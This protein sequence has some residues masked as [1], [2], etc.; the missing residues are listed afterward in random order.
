MEV[1]LTKK[2]E[3][4]IAIFIDAGV[5]DLKN[6]NAIVSFNSDGDIGAIKLERNTYR[7]GKTK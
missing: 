1:Q 2:D 5:F 7:R 6:G 4:K 3:E